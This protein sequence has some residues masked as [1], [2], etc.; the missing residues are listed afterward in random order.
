MVSSWLQISPSSPQTF[1]AP[2]TLLVCCFAALSLSGLVTAGREQS[3]NADNS[4]IK[5]AFNFASLTD[6]ACPVTAAVP[7]APVTGEIRFLYYPMARN[8]A[9]KE[10]KSLVLHVA[11]GHE[12]FPVDSK[13]LRFSLREDGVWAAT[14]NWP[15]YQA[16]K[17]AIY[18]VEEPSS[19]TTDTNGGNYF[20][21]P[22]CDLHGQL[23]ASSVQ[24]QAESYT[25]ILATHGIE[26]L[27]NYQTALQIL[28]DYIRVPRRG[29]D[30]IGRVWEYKFQMHRNDPENFPTLLQDIDKFIDQHAADGFGLLGTMVFLSQHDGVPA[31]TEDKLAEAMKVRD[32]DTNVKAFLLEARS[33]REPDKEKRIPLAQQLL[34]EFP[35]TPYAGAARMRLFNDSSDLDERERLYQEIKVNTPDL[36]R[37]DISMADAYL[38]AGYKLQQALSLLAEAEQTLD[39]NE[40]DDAAPIHYG[41]RDTKL[42]NGRIAIMRADILVRQGKPAEALAILQPWKNGFKLGWSFYVYGRALEATGD[43]RTAVDAYL[44]SVVRASQYQEDANT[45]LEKLW[46]QQK[47]G[48]KNELRQRVDALSAQSFVDQNYRP[49]LLRHTAPEFE[50]TTLNGEI[51]SSS[52]LRGK[53]VILNFWGVWCGPCRAEL[54]ELEQFQQDHPNLFVLTA[55]DTTADSKDLRDLIR[56]AG[57]K[58]LR[59]APTPPGLMEKF[60]AYGYP[61]TFIIDE[62]GFVRIEQLGGGPGISRYL[63]AGLDA[64]R[65]IGATGPVQT[66]RP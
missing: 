53:K 41:E 56:E 14:L 5:F 50:L 26:R 15:I 51:V 65:E 43:K 66:Q 3:P 19:K 16:P 54:K 24:L 2:K 35:D 52:R 10:P 42:R 44:Q 49:Q 47:L 17:Y 6:P 9:I 37:I 57:L 18:W 21:V 8:A 32:P 64:I 63:T 29:G 27:V 22:F 40:K 13:T 62:N 55:V 58:S 48:T 36:V 33:A 39:A 31:K 25:G 61:N 20:E 28:E 30:L 46:R 60:G 38:Q 7:H 23:A 59:I 11:L 34:R 4:K 1:A 45:R 12:S